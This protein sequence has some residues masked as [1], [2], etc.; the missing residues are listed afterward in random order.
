MP[1]MS[2]YTL[3]Y[4]V[5]LVPEGSVKLADFHGLD[6]G[7]PPGVLQAVNAKFEAIKSGAFTVPLDTSNAN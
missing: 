7:V 3:V 1:S 4:G 2:R 6:A 5:R